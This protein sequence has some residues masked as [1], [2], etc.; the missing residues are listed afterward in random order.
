MAATNLIGLDIGSTAVRAVE[1]GRSKDGP[2]VRNSGVVPLPPGAVSG[3][4][5]SDEAEVLAELIRRRDG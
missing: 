5:I 2:V 1:T 3:G 4:V